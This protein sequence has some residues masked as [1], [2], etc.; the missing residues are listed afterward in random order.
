MPR[1]YKRFRFPSGYVGFSPRGWFL[2]IES[3]V[4]HVL[5]PVYWIF[6]LFF[7]LVTLMKN[8]CFFL[9]K[10]YS[11]LP[12]L[13][14]FRDQWC[15]FIQILS[16]MWLNIRFKLFSFL[17]VNCF[18]FK[19]QRLEKMLVDEFSKEDEL[20]KNGSYGELVFF[21]LCIIIRWITM[22][23]LSFMNRRLWFVESEV[24]VLEDFGIFWFWVC[25]SFYSLPDSLCLCQAVLECIECVFVSRENHTKYEKK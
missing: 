11:S 7:I 25:C 10:I 17:S 6:P 24:P 9:P 8:G 21:T 1:N 4:T 2:R 15:S 22:F 19:V 23:V 13:I 16:W 14:K 5:I 3:E 12:S 20:E 18:R